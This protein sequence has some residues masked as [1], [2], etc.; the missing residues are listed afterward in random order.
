M[1]LAIFCI[2]AYEEALRLYRLSANQGDAHGQYG[3]GWLYENGK[4]V[5]QDLKEALR[6]YRLSAT[7]G[8]P[9]AK[10]RLNEI[11][12]NK[13]TARPKSKVT[14]NNDPLNIRD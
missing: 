8:H 1:M 6:L 3:L 14:K 5:K 12:K 13:P 4:G 11:N 7:Q 9:D 10:A 2:D